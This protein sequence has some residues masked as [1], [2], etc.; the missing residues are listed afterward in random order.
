VW[1]GTVA[2]AVQHHLRDGALAI[3]GFGTR[4]IVNRRGQA[5]GGARRILLALH[6]RKE[7]RCGLRRNG[8]GIVAVHRIAQARRQ[9]GK[10]RQIAGHV[11]RQVAQQLPRRRRRHRLRHATD[12]LPRRHARRSADQH[13]ANPCVSQPRDADIP[14]AARLTPAEL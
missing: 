8:R 12:A 6:L 13:H 3:D 10:P 4:L 7:G 11:E 14:H 2:H 5:V 9:P 1:K